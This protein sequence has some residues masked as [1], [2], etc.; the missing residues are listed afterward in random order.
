[1]IEEQ[2]ADWSDQVAI[3]TGSSPR[4][5]AGDWASLGSA[6]ICINYA[7]RTAKAK[8]IL[9]EGAVAARDQA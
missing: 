4:H 8:R 1:M 9:P 5:R 3:V 7:S 6:A 2:M